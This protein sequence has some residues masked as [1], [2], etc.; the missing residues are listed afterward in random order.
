ML[1]TLVPGETVPPELG[2]CV[3]G[4]AAFHIILY[5]EFYGSRIL[6]GGPTLV[7]KH[8]WHQSACLVQ[9]VLRFLIQF[10]ATKST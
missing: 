2:S 5:V 6:L 4:H 10:I 1:L 7:L 8:R 9:P 3:A